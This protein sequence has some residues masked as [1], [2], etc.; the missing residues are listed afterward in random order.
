LNAFKQLQ[1][2]HLR[3]GEADEVGTETEAST[4]TSSHT[5][6]GRHKVEHSEDRRSDEG[7]CGDLIEREG[8]AGDKD[9]GTRD[10]EALNQVLDSTI[11]NF[12]KVHLI[13]YSGQ[14]NFFWVVVICGKKSKA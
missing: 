6:G 5:D 9:S 3:T 2:I 11:H 13:L 1:Q 14:R 8:L 7:Q 12:T 4:L 10:D